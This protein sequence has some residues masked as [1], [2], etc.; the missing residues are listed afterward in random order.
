MGEVK[1]KYGKSAGSKP[2]W[3]VIPITKGWRQ[4]YP[5][6]CL[7]SWQWRNT[8]IS[9]AGKHQSDF[10]AYHLTDK[11]LSFSHG[12]TPVAMV[13]KEQAG[14]REVRLIYLTDYI[15]EKRETWLIQ[16][17]AQCPQMSSP[18]SPSTTGLSGL[19]LWSQSLPVSHWKSSPHRPPKSYIAKVW[20]CPLSQS[21]LSSHQSV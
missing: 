13:C 20:W 12:P 3:L 15:L 18:T 16:R 9:R 17:A 10:L 11:Q 8:V 6:P 5:S 2:T 21:N 19:S 7:L 14:T 4:T 1:G